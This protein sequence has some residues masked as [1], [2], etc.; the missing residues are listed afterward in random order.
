LAI[1]VFGIASH[2]DYFD[3]DVLKSEIA[4]QLADRLRAN[5]IDPDPWPGM[6]YGWREIAGWLGQGECLIVPFPKQPMI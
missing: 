1:D 6:G 3:D 4:I 2:I 5:D